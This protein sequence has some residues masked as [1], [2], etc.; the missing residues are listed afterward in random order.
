MAATLAN[1]SLI[2]RSIEELDAAQL[3]A[4]GSVLEI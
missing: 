1:C 2:I 4:A 3:R